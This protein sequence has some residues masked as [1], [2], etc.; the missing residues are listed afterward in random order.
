MARQNAM[1]NPKRTSATASALMIGVGLVGF[2]T[3][4]AA[5]V[6]AS[7]NKVV[8][9][10]MRSDFLPVRFAGTETQPFTIGAIFSEE[11]TGARL[12]DDQNRD[13]LITRSAALT[14]RPDTTDV[15][16]LV[17]AASGVSTERARAALDEATRGYATAQVQDRND[18]KDSQAAQ[19]EMMLN[20]IY[21]LLALAVVIALIGIA[22]TLA[23][24]IHE[25]RRELGLLRAVGMTRQQVRS[26]IR[27]ESV[28][29]A[30]LGTGLGLAISL[31]FG[32]VL[33][34]AMVDQGVDTLDIPAGRLA[35]IAMAGA[36][37]GIVAAILPARRAARLDTLRVISST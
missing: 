18:F 28:I 4:F 7:I 13:V 10:S 17:T 25:R 35:V 11:Q 34:Q 16:I 8:D 19:V 31:F 32:W 27:W 20:L 12:S 6:K 37:A 14:A 5:S 21:A 9:T 29:I 24:S 1:R 15:K 2:I 23:L 33:I 22:N 36:L 30:L 26:T 3:I